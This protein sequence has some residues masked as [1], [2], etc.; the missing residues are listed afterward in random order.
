MKKPLD[1]EN[2]A[3]KEH[4]HFFKKFEEPF[5]GITTELDCE[6]AYT[7]CKALGISFFIYYLHKALLAANSLEPF[8]YTIEGDEVMIFEKV[9]ASPTIMRPN[10]TFGFAYIEYFEDF[11]EFERHAKLEIDQVQKGTGLDPSRSEDNMIH[12]SSI[13]WI[14]FTAVSHARSFSFRENC[15]KIVFGKLSDNR[16]MP[17][18]I[19]VHHALMDGIHIA[20]FIEA[21]QNLM[22]GG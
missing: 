13:P 8:R 9:N 4:F 18:S 3:R 17:V 5:F 2:W 20:A 11:A 15:P 16:M 14:K 12:F 10:G 21:F 6:T 19:H 22:N 7:H 1:I